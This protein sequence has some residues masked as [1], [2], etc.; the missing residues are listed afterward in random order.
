MK[1]RLTL[2]KSSLV[3]LLCATFISACAG[4]QL[5]VPR[6]SPQGVDLERQRQLGLIQDK[7]DLDFKSRLEEWR[8]VFAVYSR[9]RT[10]GLELC[11]T[12]LKPFW[13]LWLADQS[14]FSNDDRDRAKRF[15][16][17]DQKVF[18]L[19]VSGPAA[20]AGLRAGDVVSKID[21]VILEPQTWMSQGSFLQR[22]S[23]VLAKADM[24]P[25]EIE[26]SRSQGK[27]SV[28]L[29]P[30]VGCRYPLTILPDAQINAG[31]TGNAIVIFS[32]ILSVANTDDELAHVIGHELAHNAL[33]H[34]G[35]SKSNEAVGGVI[36]AVIDIGVL[37][38][39]GINTRGVFTQLGTGEGRKAYSRILKEKPTT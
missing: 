17:I 27:Y 34:P 4:P 33:G 37:L 20:N 7:T 12:D 25:V 2:H 13:G 30:D 32:G 3:V 22:A 8:R 5:Q 19:A 35:R 11:K 26:I 38:G 21:G 6:A 1:T 39:T 15:L 9:L 24:R 31:A 36:G 10:A 23:D 14:V 28:T 18:I 16:G 29:T